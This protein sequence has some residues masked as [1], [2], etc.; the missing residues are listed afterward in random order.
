M[1]IEVRTAV[2][3]GVG[4]WDTTDVGSASWFLAQST[5]NPWGFLSHG[6]RGASPRWGVGAATLAIDL[7]TSDSINPAFRTEPR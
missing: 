1:T 6:D 7:I 2:T 4:N 5:Q 3:L